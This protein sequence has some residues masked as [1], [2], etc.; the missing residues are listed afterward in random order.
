[1]DT[2]NA[3]WQQSKCPTIPGAAVP[4][5]P[6]PTLA[7]AVSNWTNMFYGG[8]NLRSCSFGTRQSTNTTVVE[9]LVCSYDDLDLAIVVRLRDGL[10]LL[11]G[12][13]FAPPPPPL[14]PP[15]QA[16]PPK[17]TDNATAPLP[18]DMLHGPPAT[19]QGLSGCF[20]TSSDCGDHGTL[21]GLSPSGCTCV[22]EL[23]WQNAGGPGSSKYYCSGALALPM[24][25]TL[26]TH[27]S[28]SPYSCILTK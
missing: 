28:C 25:I 10:Q 8:R 5:H 3:R 9:E 13:R 17:W 12:L 20:L 2:T 27:R 7:Q 1:M 24:V 15:P 21:K 26:A 22:C 4:L 6:L 19:S 16:R 14:P 18:V 11:D 23:G